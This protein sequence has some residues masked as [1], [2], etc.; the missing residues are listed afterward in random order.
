MFL[1]NFLT[2]CSDFFNESFGESFGDTD[3][4]ESFLISLVG[5]LLT[6]LRTDGENLLIY[7]LCL[8][9]NF[10]E[11]NFL[12]YL[13]TLGLNFLI[14]DL[15]F[16]DNLETVDLAEVDFLE[17]ILTESFLIS[18]VG[19][20]LTALRTDGENLLIY[21]FC[22]GVNFLESNFLRYLI[23]LG[24]NF[25]I[26]DL[27]FGDNLETVDLADVDF[28]EDVLTESFL[29]SFVGNLLT[30]LRT[31]G[32]N[33]LINAFC[34]GVNFLESNFLR[35]L[36][37]LG[38]NFLIADLTFGDNLETVDL[39]D[40]FLTIAFIF[41]NVDLTLNLDGDFTPALTTLILVLICFNNLLTSGDFLIFVI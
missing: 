23:T 29:I 19:N 38:L 7:I 1:D 24:L 10:L 9:V 28:L 35:Y 32:E 22:F 6:A 21:A 26:A 14:A 18:L 3:L 17:D 25:L 16:G 36:I 15:T 31:A 41:F 20:L 39:A 12:R 11:S 34:F 37:T 13:I 5:N 40:V 27:T 4:T 30:A 33:F 8:G 2:N